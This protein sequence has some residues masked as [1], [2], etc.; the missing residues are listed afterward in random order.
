[1]ISSLIHSYS[2][3]FTLIHSFSLRLSNI[4]EESDV[5]EAHR[6]ISS[7]MQKTCIDPLTGRLDLDM[8]TTGISSRKLALQSDQRKMLLSLLRD[9]EHTT[10]AF[11]HVFHDFNAR[12]V[13]KSN[14]SAKLSELDF[15]RL[16]DSIASEDLIVV[17]GR[18][19]ADK[20]ILLK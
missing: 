6:L 3:L 2:L 16:V 5:V 15:A 11:M 17:R 10:L 18:S 19:N 9:S 7:A 13:A 8:I 12:I 20:T 1:M 4:V 14:A